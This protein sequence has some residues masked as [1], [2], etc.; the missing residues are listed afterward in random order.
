MDLAETRELSANGLSHDS[1]NGAGPVLG[2]DDAEGT[3]E[4]SSATDGEGDE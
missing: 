4:P 3:D 2:E 1:E